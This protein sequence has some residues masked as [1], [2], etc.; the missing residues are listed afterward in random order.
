MPCRFETLDREK[1][2]TPSFFR[3]SCVSSR[4]APSPP[5]SPHSVEVGADDHVRGV[6]KS[7]QRGRTGN[8]ESRRLNKCWPRGNYRAYWLRP[9]FGIGR[10]A[11]VHLRGCKLQACFPTTQVHTRSGYMVPTEQGRPGWSRE[12]SNKVPPWN[13]WMEDWTRS[14]L[15]R[16][17]SATSSDAPADLNLIT[18]SGVRSS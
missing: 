13:D 9:R 5:P 15:L 6:H 11:G 3:L 17:I 2:R 7:D 16:S 18:R 1:P 8:T 14:K 10:A 12:Q 4:S